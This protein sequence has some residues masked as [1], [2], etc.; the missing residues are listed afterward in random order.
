MIDV[1]LRAIFL[2]HLKEFKEKYGISCL[3]ITHDFNTAY[4]IADD[5]VVLNCGRVVEM[6][7]MEEVIKN[8]YHPYTKLLIS[9]IPIP[10]PK[11]RWR[12][13]LKVKELPVR[14]LRPTKGCVFQQ[15]CPYVMPQCK[16][17]TPCLVEVKPDHFV[18]CFLYE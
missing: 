5:V 2:D 15:R 10:D 13:K 6:G 17:K 3:Y 8:P 9:S 1:S 4:Y 12:G 16:E 18:A 11:K 7:K 14:E